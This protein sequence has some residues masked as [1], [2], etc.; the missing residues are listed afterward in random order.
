MPHP[1]IIGANT[2]GWSHFT[3]RRND[4]AFQKTAGAIYKRDN[5]T[6]QFCGFK[7]D[8]FQDIVNLDEN[9]KN[10]DQKNM[11]TSCRFCT[12]T[13]F[14]GCGAA[15][16][17]IIYFPE[18]PQAELN[19]FVRV[20]FCSM[21][22]QSE[23]AESSKSLYRNFRNRSAIVEQVFGEG[24]SEAEIFGQT[25]IDMGPVEKSREALQNFRWL[26]NKSN[27]EKVIEYWA[28]QVVPM[29]PSLLQR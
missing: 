27:Y 23:Y 13:H 20:L 17:K 16:G 8:K 22:M 3:R 12:M 19:N 2:D 10:N 14:L 4:A 11:V 15:G 26:P 29:A 5:H 28:T 7:A 9:Y 24:S 25:L 1:L 21:A 18:L 6:C